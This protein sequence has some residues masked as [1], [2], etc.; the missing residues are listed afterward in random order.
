LPR[1]RAGQQWRNQSTLAL[2]RV[3]VG[4]DVGNQAAVRVVNHLRLP[5]QRRTT[6]PTQR[7]QALLAVRQVMAVEHAQAPAWQ[8]RAAVH[9]CGHRRQAL[10]AAAHQG[11]QDGRLG[12][13][14]PVIQRR[15]RDRQR[16]YRPRRRMQR[17]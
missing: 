9:G 12:A 1:L 11:A 16:R 3:L 13:V 4:H 8:E 2:V 17:A 15:Q 7:R 10:G 6:M 5:R 14:D